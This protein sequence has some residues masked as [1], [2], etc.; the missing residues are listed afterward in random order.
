[1][2]KHGCVGQFQMVD[3][4]RAGEMAVNLTRRLNKSGVI[5]PKLDVQ[6]KDLEKWGN[7]LLLSHQFGFMI[8]TISPG[9]MDQEEA[10]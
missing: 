10:R 5:G 3:D 4:H 8:L 7:N 1:M 9:I 6:L 2:M